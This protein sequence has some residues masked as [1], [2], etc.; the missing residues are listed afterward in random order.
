M[1]LNAKNFDFTGWSPAQLEQRRMEVIAEARKFTNMDDVPLDTLRELSALTGAIRRG[2]AGPPKN[3]R[4]D[5][6]GKKRK[7][8]S[9]ELLGSI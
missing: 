9:D 7:L 5:S 4:K 3:A 1:T 6:T 8:S 2:T